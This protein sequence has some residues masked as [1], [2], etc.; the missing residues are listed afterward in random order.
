[1]KNQKPF[2]FIAHRLFIKHHKI[3]HFWVSDCIHGS[4]HVETGM[5][6]TSLIFIP[7]W[8]PPWKK[9]NQTEIKCFKYL[10]LSFV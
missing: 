2:A 1:M 4:C 9:A 5:R 10:L 3:Y 8:P 6:L 7:T